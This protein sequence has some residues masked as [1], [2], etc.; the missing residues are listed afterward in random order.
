MAVSEYVEERVK[1]IIGIN[2]DN[3]MRSLLNV[4]RVHVV[5][6]EEM[7]AILEKVAPGITPASLWEGKMQRD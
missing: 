6:D 5:K 2:R 4:Q 1:A 7:L 3:L